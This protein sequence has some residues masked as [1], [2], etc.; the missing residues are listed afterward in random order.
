MK[1]Q[2]ASSS[3]INQCSSVRLFATSHVRWWQLGNY[4]VTTYISLCQISKR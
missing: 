2:R 1:N 4:A 3:S